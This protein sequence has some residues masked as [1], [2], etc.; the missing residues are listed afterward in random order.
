MAYPAPSKS[1]PLRAAAALG[2]LMGGL[3]G[4]GRALASPKLQGVGETSVGYTDNIQSAP[5]VP[6][7][8]GAPKTDGAF[9]VLSTTLVLPTASCPAIHLLMYTTSY[10][11]YLHP[12]S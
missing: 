8:G 11:I 1:A 6:I 12:S 10:D 4:S 3:A 2:L 5:N 9:G 7:P